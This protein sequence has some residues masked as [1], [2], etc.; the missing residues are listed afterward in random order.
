MGRA[1]KE[2]GDKYRAERLDKEMKET[3][4]KDGR[5]KIRLFGKFW[6][7]TYVFTR[8]VNGGNLNKGRKATAGRNKETKIKSSKEFCYF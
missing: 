1:G 6:R 7:I 8:N 5:W 4:E 3:D 2:R